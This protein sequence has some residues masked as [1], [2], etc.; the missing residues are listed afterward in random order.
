MPVG[1]KTDTISFV[2]RRPSVGIKGDRIT[3]EQEWLLHP[4]KGW[5]RGPKRYRSEPLNAYN[6]YPGGVDVAV[7]WK[8]WR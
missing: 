2:R 1:V 5:K 8:S 7:R 3:I 4:T 6:R